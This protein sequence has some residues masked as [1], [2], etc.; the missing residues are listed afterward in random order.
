MINLVK[1]LREATGLGLNEC[2]EALKI[3]DGDL[4]KALTSVRGKYS[5]PTEIVGTNGLLDYCIK[6]VDT[7]SIEYTIG[8]IRT[9]TDFGANCPE[10]RK[11]AHEVVRDPL[12][13]N[14]MLGEIRAIT[15][16]N[17][18]IK[19]LKINL[20]A[21]RDYGVYLHHDQRS[22]GFV[23]FNK[24][25]DK[26][27]AKDIAMHIVANT[28]SPTV[29]SPDKVPTEWLT[30]EREFL[31]TKAMGKPEEI[32]NKIVKGGLDKFAQSISL[33][34]QPFI[35]DPKVRVC[36]ILPTDCVTHFECY[37]ILRS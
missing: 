21:A 24:E 15:K 36:D 16:E 6:L 5:K 28:P 11:F 7:N 37:K 32:K 33:L 18:V 1:Q 3:S 13:A 10:V 4:E 30:R 27:T 19:D 23:F 8:E 20:I 2:V 22:L 9:D 12:Y 34:T 31:E 17:I 29:V 25:I 14:S 35:K 26:G